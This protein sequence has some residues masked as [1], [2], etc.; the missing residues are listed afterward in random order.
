MKSFDTDIKKYTERTHLKASERRELRE[1][2]FAYMEYHPLPKQPMEVVKLSEGL[3]S[4]SFITL[5]F[6]PLYAR[7]ASGVLVLILVVAPFVAERSVPGDVLYLVKTGVNE[8]I[9]GQLANSPYEKIVFETKLMERRITEARV[10]ANEG[11]LTEE[12]QTQIAETVKGHTD[13]VQQGLAELREQDADGAALAQ[14]TFNTSLEVQTAMIQ[15]TIDTAT[16][17]APMDSILVIVNDAHEQGLSDQG[18]DTPSYEG[19]IAQVERET[20]RAY[21]LFADA[22]D[23]ATEEEIGDINRRLDDINRMTLEAKERNTTNPE[24]SAG[25]LATTLGL[26]QK[27]IAFMTDIDVR[28]T[29]DLENLVPVILSDEERARSVQE[30]M[31]VLSTVLRDE[32]R[33]RLDRVDDLAVREKVESGLITI[34]ESLV[35][36]TIA[37]EASDVAL[38]EN[39]VKEA[40]ALMT[41]IDVMTQYVDEIDPTLT[42]D[43]SSDDETE[44]IADP[45]ISEGGAT[46]SGTTTSSKRKQE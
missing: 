41:D 37:L 46:E 22:K 1:R 30:E 16:D 6:N 19:L 31:T 3:L 18:G 28:N 45:V 8:T 11:K 36:A 2:I 7:I 12:V 9:Q 10:L 24:M 23:L 43:T 34:D 20:T 14:I 15:A 29:V 13:A 17:T 39:V 38:A 27:L 26:I 44:V 5:H 21:E 40:R 42:D 4:E 33:A 25:D 32:I 35:K